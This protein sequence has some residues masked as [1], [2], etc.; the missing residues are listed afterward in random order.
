MTYFNM[1]IQDMYNMDD[2]T[3]TYENELINMVKNWNDWNWHTA[4]EI[5]KIEETYDQNWKSFIP[6]LFNFK[7]DDEI[8]WRWN[9]IIVPGKILM[10]YWVTEWKNVNDNLQHLNVTYIKDYTWRTVNDMTDTI[11]LPQRY[12]PA[13]IKLVYDW[14]APIS[15]LAGETATTDFFSHAMQRMEKL[16]NNDSLTNTPRIKTNRMITWKIYQ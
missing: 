14:A 3:F 1:A 15:M 11:P 6:T 8:R 12:I 13:L 9:T 7:E 10:E 5:K 4:Y 2:A 16:V